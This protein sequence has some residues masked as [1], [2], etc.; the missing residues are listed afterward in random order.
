MVVLER[1]ADCRLAYGPV[2]ATATH[3]LFSKIQIG[4]I[5]LVPAY[6][7]SPRKRAIKHVCVYFTYSVQH[8]QV[9]FRGY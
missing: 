9:V 1:G 7:S 5:F 6:P 4:F 2:D 3:C 8:Q